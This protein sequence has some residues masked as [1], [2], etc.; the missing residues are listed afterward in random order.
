[1]AL[2]LAA[3]AGVIWLVL[4][5]SDVYA[6]GINCG[7]SGKPNL[8]LPAGVFADCDADTTGPLAHAYSG[9]ASAK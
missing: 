1:V 7:T 3:I 6:D 4:M 5:F 9:I 2:V 8:P